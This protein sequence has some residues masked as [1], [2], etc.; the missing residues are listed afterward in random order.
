MTTRLALCLLSALCGCS[1]GHDGSAAKAI[2]P[3]ILLIYTDD[4]G[5]ADLGVQGVDQDVRTPNLDRLADDGVVFERGYVTAPQCTPSRAGV[6]TGM[7]QN[8]FGV[9]RNGI[10]MPSEVVTL[11]ERLKQAGYVSGISGKWHLDV[12]ASS[13]HAPR[14]NRF[15]PELLPHR[16]GFDEYFTGFLQDYIASHAL[17]GTPFPDAPRL[18]SEEGCRVVIQTEA[19]LSFLE[20]REPNPEQPW[21]FYLAYTAPHFPLESPEP[22]F[23]QTPEDLP[24]KRRQALAMIGAIDDGVGRLREKLRAMG[25]EQNTLIFFIG[26][27]GAPLGAGWDGSI[28]WPMRGGKNMLSEGGIR[29][30]FVAAWPGHIP[31]GRVYERPVISLDVA[32]TALALSG[33]GSQPVVPDAARTGSLGADPTGGKPIPPAPSPLDGVNLMPFL[34]GEKP[35]VPH[36]TLYWRWMSQAAVQE[37]PWKL[38]ALGDRERLLFDV[39][40]PDGESV[41]GNLIATQPAIAARLEAKLEGWCDTLEPPGLPASFDRNQ[42]KLFAEHGIIAAPAGAAGSGGSKPEGSR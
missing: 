38:I 6:L 36:E 20:R 8:R 35:G 10:P 4:H 31:A 3:N 9:E 7:Y 32:A 21:F 17:D 30:P 39:T 1:L 14:R 12:E 33:M 41:S 26:D 2:R 27:N 28:N 11:P 25:Q 40:H 15:L 5:W 24:V 13:N 37:F 34:T 18:V 29:V 23:S 42:E 22:W 19:A 16:Q